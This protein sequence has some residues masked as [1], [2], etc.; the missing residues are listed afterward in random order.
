MFAIYLYDKGLIS[1]IYKE[2]K[3]IYKKKITLSKRAK[4]ELSPWSSEGLLKN[5]LTKGVKESESVFKSSN[6]GR[7]EIQN[8]RVAAARDCGSR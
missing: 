4:G 7:R 5:Q 6:T 2:F 3:H 8:G 1:R